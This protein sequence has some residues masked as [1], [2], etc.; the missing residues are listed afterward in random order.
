MA[1]KLAGLP[2]GRVVAASKAAQS[3][4][5]DELPTDIAPTE[6]ASPRPFARL[7][8]SS[9][10]VVAAAFAASFVAFLGLFNFGIFLDSLIEEFG[11]GKGATAAV[12]SVTSFVYYQSGMVAG[13]LADRYGPRPVI[14]ASAMLIGTGLVVGSQARTLWQLGLIWAVTLGP[15]VGASYSPLVAAVGARF[16]RQRSVALGIALA[17][18]G[19]GIMA[20]APICNALLHAYGWRTSFVLLGLG[21][22][23][24]LALC[25]LAAKRPPGRQSPKPAPMGP[26]LRTRS[27]RLLFL[28]VALLSLAFFT[29]FV[30][31]ASYATS[32]GMNARTTSL[33]VG[34]VGLSS[35]LGRLVL[36]AVAG[37]LGEIGIYQLSYGLMA[38]SF[39]VWLVAGRSAVALAVFAVL[40][41][42]GYGGMVGLAPSVLAHKFGT[43]RLGGLVG[44]LYSGLG[45][46][47]VISPPFVG[48]LTDRFGATPGILFAFIAALG[49][50]AATLGLRREPSAG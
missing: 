36:G 5:R 28:G 7:L 49:A 8:R 44:T 42:T 34:L 29:P 3:I 35:T 10:I 48:W 47:V 23:F 12:F 24:I 25:A 1:K 43:D 13:R 50:F 4:W 9:W 2:S 19:V 45:W 30:F 33:I 22:A 40:M 18:A 15:G 20:G 38:A 26:M 21:S 32:H 46:G 16:E 17:G 41:G 27:F 6:L 37:K 14:A 39:G 31:L 11:Q